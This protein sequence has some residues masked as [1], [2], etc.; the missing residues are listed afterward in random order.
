MKRTIFGLAAIV[1]AVAV[2]MLA[3]CSAESLMNAGDRLGKLSSAG[4]GTGGDAYVTKAT[5]TING[6]IENYEDNILWDGSCTRTVDQETGAETING[7]LKRIANSDKAM[8]ELLAD[9]IN[10]VQKAR[11]SKAADAELRKALDTLYKDYDG[12][13][14][15]YKGQT[16]E[17][18]GHVNV[19]DIIDS[20]HHSIVNMIAQVAAGLDLTQYYAINLP[21]PVQGSDLSTLLSYV[22]DNILTIASHA[23]A[24]ANKIKRGGGGGESK[25]DI[26][27]LKYIPD[28]IEKYVNGRKDVTVGDKIAFCF[29]YDIVQT[30]IKVLDRYVEEHPDES[31]DTMFDSL[32]ADWILGSCGAEVDKLMAEL[33]VVSY[34]Y[35]FNLDVA[36]LV[37]KIL[38]E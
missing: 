33:E 19:K 25:F 2:L 38:G 34:I 29:L 21:F 36:G 9:V 5:A 7:D 16:I 1:V 15:S 8:N 26:K 35:D 37:G 18:Y 10:C 17:W 32:T 14:Q 4:F 12:Q 24:L 30:A 6:F 20:V 3:G 27:Q 22:R 13:K 11:E 28:S 31:D 23:Y